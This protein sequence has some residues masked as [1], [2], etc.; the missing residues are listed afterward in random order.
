MLVSELL[1]EDARRL[2][3]LEMKL[4]LLD[5]SPSAPSGSGSSGAMPSYGGSGAS[6][7]SLAAD[8]HI[9]LQEMER[10][11]KDLDALSKKESKTQ[12][13]VARRRLVH[14]RTSFDH[15]TATFNTLLRKKGISKADFQK[16]AL[17]GSY[18]GGDA[19]LE[20]LDLEM[21]ENSSLNRSA[22]MLDGYLA[23]GRS[24]LEELVGQRERL[25]NAQ[26]KVYDIMNLLGISNTIM[27]NVENREAVDRL[28]V[29]AGMFLISILLLL[30]Y[31]Y[32]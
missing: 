12:R 16:K 5:L 2:H 1:P 30:I 31:M 19:S 9:G 11:L 21:A 25:K 14:M 8:I 22:Q 17:F 23:S 27:K 26:R 15:V 13:D 28:I 32:R 20:S 3:E 7:V 24:A 6:T 10:R 4:E 18:Y 29:F